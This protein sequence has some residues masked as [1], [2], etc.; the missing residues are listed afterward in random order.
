MS[1]DLMVFDPIAAPKEREAFLAW[2][3]EQTEWSEPHSYGDP[4]V[5][6][7]R[8]RAWFLD[9]IETFP[10]M[11]GPFA[12]KDLQ[13]DEASSTDYS[14]GS[15]CIYAAFAWSKSREAYDTVFMLA[16]KHGLGFYDVSSA[17]G[18]VRLPDQLGNLRLAHSGDSRSESGARLK[19]LLVEPKK[20]LPDA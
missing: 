11:N 5:A 13:D 9:M 18:Q 14:V 1:Y 15:V 17:L 12:P 10:A 7:E 4:K 19:A 8:L 3:R 6:T 16:E 20:T 2:Y